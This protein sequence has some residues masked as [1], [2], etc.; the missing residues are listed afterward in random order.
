M[1]FADDV[2]RIECRAAHTTLVE[3]DKGKR[4]HLVASQRRSA[5][6]RSSRNALALLGAGGERI[7]WDS[8]SG[9]VMEEIV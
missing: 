8:A 7:L 1:A 3:P 9:A 6:E 2:A 5:A 4:R